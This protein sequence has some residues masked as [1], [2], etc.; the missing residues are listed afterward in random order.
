MK[1]SPGSAS[2]VSSS[3]TVE[4]AEERLVDEP[5]Y[6]GEPQRLIAGLIPAADGPMSPDMRQALTERRELIE[7]RADAVLDTAIAAHEAWTRAL[8]EPTPRPA[9]SCHL[10][11]R[12]ARTIAAYRD[13]YGITEGT[14]LGA[15]GSDIQKIDRARAASALQTIEMAT[16]APEHGRRP[17][18][19]VA[20]GLGI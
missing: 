11:H 9:P 5:G 20:R 1:G 2:M 12:H 8:G 6:T 19:Q 13:R 7:N 16:Q 17:V 18:R 15:P 14:P 10:A 3:V 4:L